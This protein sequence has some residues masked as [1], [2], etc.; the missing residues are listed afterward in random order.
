MPIQVESELGLEC[1]ETV[2]FLKHQKRGPHSG[3][4]LLL[5]QHLLS[6]YGCLVVIVHIFMVILSMAVCLRD[7]NLND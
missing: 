5:Y 2:R 6:G 3:A 4:S 1:R 7:M